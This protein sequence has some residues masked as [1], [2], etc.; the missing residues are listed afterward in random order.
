MIIKMFVWSIIMHGIN[1]DRYVTIEDICHMTIVLECNLKCSH[2]FCI[3][4]YMAHHVFSCTVHVIRVY[5]ALN[6]ILLVY[7]R[8]MVSSVSM[9]G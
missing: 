5:I 8:G 2:L 1:L 4:N 6:K 3:S 7:S 9:V